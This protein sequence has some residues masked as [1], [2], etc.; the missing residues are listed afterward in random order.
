MK[1]KF[2]ATSKELIAFA[3]VQEAYQKSGDITT[4]LMPLFAPII[5]A[6]SGQV[7]DSTDFAKAV[8]EKYD[9]AMRPIVA[10]SLIPKLVETGL[11]T[12]EEKSQYVAVYRCVA[13]PEANILPNEDSLNSILNEFCDFAEEA[14]SRQ[15]FPVSN[16]ELRKGFIE[17]LKSIEFLHVIDG[18]S[19]FQPA[20]SPDKS[21]D[22]TSEEKT[23]EQLSLA[24][25]VLSAEYILA[26]TD[27]DSSRFDL[28]VRIASGA[29]I[30]DVVLTLQQSSA[31]TN[32]SGLT[33]V[34]DGPLIMDLLDLNTQESLHFSQDLMNLLKNAH[35][36]VV[37]F[38][39][40]VEEMGGAIYAPLEAFNNGQDAYGP[41]AA[42]LR[43]NPNHAAYARAVLDGLN[44]FIVNLDITI[45]DASDFEVAE[46]IQYCSGEI[47]DALR[48]CLGPLHERVEPRIRDA[49]SI[50]N[51]MRM[52]KG[53]SSVASVTESKF[54]FV[55]RN[56]QVARRTTDCLHSKR[57]VGYDDVPP[58]ILDRQLAG[59]LWLCLGGS[60]DRLT[61]E[62][63]LANCMDALYPR[64]NLLAT[65]RRFL[66]NLDPEKGQVFEAL[67]RDKR[68]QRCLL[69][70]TLGYTQ[71]VT[72]DNVEELLEEIRR[73][74]AEEVAREARQREKTLLE[75]H[76]KELTDKTGELN[77][78]RKDAEKLLKEKTELESSRD[79]IIL[80]ALKR[81]CISAQTVQR[82]RKALIVF[83]YAL[84]VIAVTYFSNKFGGLLASIPCGLVAVLG[85][86][87]IPEKLLK[88][89]IDNAWQEKFNDEIS[90]SNIEEYAKHFQ[91]DRDS[92][93][94]K[95]IEVPTDV[96]L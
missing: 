76:D 56:V 72:Q 12:R 80:G 13:G 34:L 69:H 16:V 86:W 4:G 29:L 40:V 28:I 11:L 47:E 14:L 39:H 59:V 24:L 20:Q 22:V 58:C 63:L 15:K 85:F 87:F 93:T 48:N 91:V 27:K 18:A 49:K 19:H 45:V 38:K 37:T 75:E 8:Q 82:R 7:F 21:N 73:A 78:V 70:R 84:L 31:N 52:R 9:I 65:V 41:L 3:Y 46:Y 94:A 81:A 32:L 88:K 62:K 43:Q 44:E 68:A 64:P 1:D 6:R 54:V 5:H 26:L 10:E 57:V 66:D 23:A 53:H 90:K 79:E 30:A 50:A 67:M 2:V 17:R 77:L 60:V 74:T 35:I 61:R 25:D 89:W 95:K 96:S 42:R 33:A 71:T 55:T 36:N 92:C 51:V 83:C